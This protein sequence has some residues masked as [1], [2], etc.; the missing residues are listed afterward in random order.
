MFSPTPARDAS[1]MCFAME[2][3]LDA[4]LTIQ[5]AKE[6]LESMAAWARVDGQTTSALGRHL[7]EEALAAHRARLAMTR[8]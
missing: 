5:L 1:V 7:I 3:G 8:R 6:T 4:R 2:R